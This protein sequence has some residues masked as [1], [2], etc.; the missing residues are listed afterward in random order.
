VPDRAGT[1]RVP[2][3]VAIAAAACCV[4]HTVLLAFGVAGA[5]AALRAASDSW[6]VLAAAVG[7]LALTGMAVAAGV[8]RR[9]T[10]PLERRFERE[11]SRP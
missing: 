6:W 11:R 10:H 5:A 8:R 3:F 2:L 7:G 4:A 9:R 1:G